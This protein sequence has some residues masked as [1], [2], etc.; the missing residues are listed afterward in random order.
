MNVNKKIQFKWN[1]WK[2]Y[3]AECKDARL[4]IS[5]YQLFNIKY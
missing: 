1:F 4:N 5:K 3:N 2:F